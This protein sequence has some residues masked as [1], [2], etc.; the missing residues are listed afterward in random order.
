[1]TITNPSPSTAPAAHH[2]LRG[3]GEG[4]YITAGSNANIV[5][6]NLSIDGGGRQ[7][8]R[9]HCQ[10]QL[11]NIMNVLIDGCLI[12]GFTQI[13]VGLGSESPMYLTVRNTSIQGG[14]LG[15]RTSRTA[16]LRRSPTTTTYN[17]I[18]SPS[19]APPLT[20]SLPAMATWTSSTPPSREAL[21]VWL[22]EFRQIPMPRSTC[23]AR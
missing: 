4:I 20:A 17:S 14:Q 23:R 18:M 15:V 21:G 5:L 11:R 9:L 7:R 12:A 22:L 19:R 1:V 6:R 10:R 13:G 8:R 2:Q 3:D 16:R